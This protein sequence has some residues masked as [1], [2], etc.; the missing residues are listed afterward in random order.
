MN[1]RRPWPP[2][3]LERLYKAT[4]V[5]ATYAEVQEIAGLHD[6]TLSAIGGQCVLHK[7]KLMERDIRHVAQVRHD[8][9]PKG[10]DV[11]FGRLMNGRRF[12]DHRRAAPAVSPTFY[13]PPIPMTL[14]GVV[15]EFGR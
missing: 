15:G 3:E 6:R 2:E 7:W 12:T 14:G 9:P 13:R 10:D 1:R 11:A 4:L 5:A 8:K